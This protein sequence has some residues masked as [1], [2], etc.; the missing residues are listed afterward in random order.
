MTGENVA[1]PGQTVLRTGDDARS[2]VPHVH[3]IISALYRQRQLSRE[4][5]QQHVRDAALSQ[6][7]RPDDARWEHDAGVQPF[8]RR[9]QHQRRGHGLALCVI[10]PHKLRG[11]GRRLRNFRALRLFRNRM[12]GADVDQLANAALAAEFQNISRAVHIDPVDSV[13]GMGG[14]GDHPRAV[15]D[16]GMFIRARE[17]EA[18]RGFVAHVARYDANILRKL[19]RQRITLHHQCTDFCLRVPQLC[20]HST[21]QKPRRACNQIFFK[22]PITSKMKDRC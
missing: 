12:D 14:H 7:A 11:K 5:G 20:Q 1:V 21:S 13:A 19:P 2:Y 6:I 4:E 15:N 8:L 16:A 3:E 18:E 22:H 9:L 10:A 17:E